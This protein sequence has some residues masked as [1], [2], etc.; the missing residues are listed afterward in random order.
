MC[1]PGD[2][3]IL[4]AGT[5]VGSITLFDLKEFS[6]SNYRL[7]E[8]DYDV[9]DIIASGVGSILAIVTFELLLAI[10]QRRTIE[11]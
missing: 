10:R 7:E 6:S 8:L 4:L 5:T 11:N 2:D 9:Y 3:S 1:T